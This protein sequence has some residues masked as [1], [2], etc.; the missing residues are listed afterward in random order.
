M[1]KNGHRGYNLQEPLVWVRVG[2]DMYKRRGGWKYVQSQR[3]LFRYMART[4]F[5]TTGQYRIQ[6]LVRLIGAIIPSW[7]R[8]ILFQRLLRN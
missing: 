4:G 3:N 5:I 8:A 2:K 1:L 7:V 6:S